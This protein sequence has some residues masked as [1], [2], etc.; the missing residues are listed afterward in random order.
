MLYRIWFL[1]WRGLRRIFTGKSFLIKECIRDFVSSQT[2]CYFSLVFK[3][4][5]IFL[6]YFCLLECKRLWFILVPGPSIMWSTQKT[7]HKCLLNKFTHV[8]APPLS[9]QPILNYPPSGQPKSNSF[10]KS[11]LT[12]PQMLFVLGKIYTINAIFY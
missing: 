4:S 3:Q 10:I 2:P 9:H 6:L 11:L 8:A 5:I 1:K 7:L 12:S